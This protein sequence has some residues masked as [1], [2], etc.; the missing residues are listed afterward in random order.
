MSRQFRSDDTYPWPFGTGSGKDGN[1]VV[2]S[3]QDLAMIKSL[4][5]STTSLG[6]LTVPATNASFEAGQFVK[7]IQMRGANSGLFEWNVIKSYVAGTVELLFPTQN[8]YTVGSANIAQ[9][10]VYK[11][12]LNVTVQS[13]FTL[14][15][16]QWDPST[17]G[18]ILGFF[19]KGT[20]DVQGLIS[21]TGRGFLGGRESTIGFSNQAQCGE[22]TGGAR[23]FQQTNNGNGGGGGKKTASGGGVNSGGG[24]SGGNK[25]A[26]LS[27]Y[28]IGGA[29]T[30][31]E[32]GELSSTSDA[33]TLTM[34]G[35]GG[36]GPDGAESGPVVGLNWGGNGGAIISIV[37]NKLTAGSIDRIV[38]KAQK[39]PNGGNSNQDGDGGTG[40]PGSVALWEQIVEGVAGA[41]NVESLPGTST[42]IGPSRE[43]GQGVCHINFLVNVTPNETIGN[44]IASLRRDTS[45]RN[46][47]GGIS[48]F[49]V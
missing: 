20:L 16:E 3:N 22:G 5:A 14:S 23:A 2:S 41:I 39:S 7:I 6:S 37:G 32:G 34:G 38:S 8:T 4:L 49:L 46:K 48:S 15:A 25:T 29:S 17:G 10:V 1:L 9:I 12:Y 43:S 11:Q 47:R 40:A 45:L 27:G 36:C 44:P 18:G 24:G 21:G 35:G 19:H 26:G 13:G 28:N 42:T 30:G 31:G 33:T